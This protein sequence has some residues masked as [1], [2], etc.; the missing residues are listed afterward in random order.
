MIKFLPLFLK[1]KA[2]ACVHGFTSVKN[3]VYKKKR[4]NLGIWLNALNLTSFFMEKPF[5]PAGE[6]LNLCPKL[7]MPGPFLVKYHLWCPIPVLIFLVK[8]WST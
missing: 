4:E 6:L 7:K 3:K 8:L 5:L 2:L 1:D